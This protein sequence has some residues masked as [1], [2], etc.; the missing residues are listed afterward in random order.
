MRH[1]EA[2]SLFADLQQIQQARGG[3]DRD[4]RA[5]DVG[6]TGDTLSIDAFYDSFLS[7]PR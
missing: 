1:D 3:R 4:G 2:F 5:V 7:R 6:Q